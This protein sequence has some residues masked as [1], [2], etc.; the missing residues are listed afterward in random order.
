MTMKKKQTKT[1]HEKKVELAEASKPSYG[2][3]IDGGSVE[4]LSEAISLI[5]PI[6]IGVIGSDSEEKTKRLALDIIKNAIPGVDACS[7]SDV[8]INMNT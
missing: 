4:K 5:G 3:Y 2:I 1:A 6:V 7:I 8:S